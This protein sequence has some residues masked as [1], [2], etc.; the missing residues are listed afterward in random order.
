MQA[1]ASRSPGGAAAVTGIDNY[2][3]SI[4]IKPREIKETRTPHATRS[5]RQH[6]RSLPRSLHLR[7]SVW[8][9]NNQMQTFCTNAET[10]A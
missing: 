6:Y 1:G 2:T 4:K 9:C 10:A 5:C 7:R 3:P 8:T